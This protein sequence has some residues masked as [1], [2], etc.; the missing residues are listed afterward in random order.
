MAPPV[1]SMT[2]EPKNITLNNWNFFEKLTIQQL[3]IYWTLHPVHS[4]YV[5]FIY[6]QNKTCRQV[7]AF[8]KQ[9]QKI[10]ISNSVCEN[11]FFQN[12]E[13]KSTVKTVLLFL[14]T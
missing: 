7:V 5:S 11:G 14:Y 9:V 2:E 12:Q 10:T 6:K 1:W 3:G 13:D 4:L 8:W